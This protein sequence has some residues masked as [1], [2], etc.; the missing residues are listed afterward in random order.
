MAKAKSRR[1][2]AER[3]SR[4]TLLRFLRDY[5]GRAPKREIVR[6]FGLGSADRAWLTTVLRDLADQGLIDR[7]G[8][9]RRSRPGLPPVAVLAVTHVDADGEAWAAPESWDGEA[10]ALTVRLIPATRTR[11]PGIGDRVLARVRAGHDG[12]LEGRPIRVLESE[13]S[14][15][16]GVFELSGG[17]GRIVPTNRR[18][19][20]EYPVQG[21]DS[22]GAQPGEVV[23]AVVT[24]G[25]GRGRR[26][27]RIRER[28]GDMNDPRTLSLI[29]VEEHGIPHRFSNE[30]L[31]EAERAAKAP[32]ADGHTDLRDV[33]FVT[34]DPVDARDFDD[35]VWAAPDDDPGNRGG[36]KVVVAIADVAHYVRP[37][38]A[39]DAEARERGNSVYFPDHVIPMLPDLLSGGACSLREGEDRACMVVRLTVDARGEIRDRR[40]ER[41]W[42]RAAK[43][44]TY[45]DAQRTH[46][47]G[48]TPVGEALL[49]PLYGAFRA[50]QKARAAREPLEVESAELEIRLGADGHVADIQPRPRLDSHRLIED[51]MIAA[52]VAAAEILESSSLPTMSRVHDEPDRERVE[53]LRRFLDS[54]GYRLARGQRLRPQDFNQVLHKFRA[55]PQAQAVN[56]FVLRTQAQAVYSGISGSHFGLSLRRYVHFT[57]PIRRYADLLV[58]RALISALGLGTDG[59]PAGGADAQAFAETAAHVSMTE[60]RADA[61][62]RD[63]ASRYLAAFLA[64]Q[65][66]GRFAARISG[67]GRAGLFVVLTE[68]GASAI[69]PL[70]TLR[71]DHYRLDE[72]HQRFVGEATARVLRLG[73]SVDVELLEANAATGGLVAAIV[74]G[75]T[76]EP[77]AKPRRRGAVRRRRG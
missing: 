34:I 67:F 47:H 44:F 39:L 76:T 51:F 29:A 52:N 46:D 54:L 42:M 38:G 6:A 28:I 17:Q 62:E 59:F 12:A 55:T 74:A 53:T 63:A 10:P 13:P 23:R 3:P 48:G 14:E 2:A 60:R 4:E 15:V 56:E 7:R 25:A 21:A 43:R 65:A 1:S 31:A 58:H 24:G 20:T 45:E 32:A 37:G 8:K 22:G 68:T 61:A 40:M 57:S 75:G 9:G 18:L 41:G 49:Q 64:P 33:P 11:A 19:R 16:V 35:A 77:S 50:L 70:R 36:W 26:R 66:G 71:D 69:V 30:A 73:D 72:P 27:A 5:E